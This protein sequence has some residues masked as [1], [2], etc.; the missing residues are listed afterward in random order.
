MKGRSLQK[1]QPM[2]RM[3]QASAAILCS[4]ETAP[5]IWAQD[6]VYANDRR[7]FGDKMTKKY[8]ESFPHVFLNV[9]NF[10]TEDVKC[11]KTS[12]AFKLIREFDI[13][14]FL[15][16]EHGLKSMDITPANSWHSRTNGQ[17]QCSRTH[18]AWNRTW[19]HQTPR[20]WGG[21][22][23]FGRL[24]SFTPILSYIRLFFSLVPNLLISS[25]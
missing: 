25:L 10:A 18:L 15:F 24:L 7:S 17:F 21:K 3:I 6:A 4:L 20:K 13:D 5:M 14:R 8:R 23:F 12:D 1:T 9:G 16:V 2:P 19:K 11:Q 22:V